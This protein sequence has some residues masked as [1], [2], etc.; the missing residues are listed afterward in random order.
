MGCGVLETSEKNVPGTALLTDDD[1][2]ASVRAY[3]E[4]IDVSNNAPGIVR[5][6]EA[7]SRI[8]IQHKAHETEI[9]Q[10][11]ECAHCVGATGRSRHY[12]KQRG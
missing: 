8:W 7:K 2:L 6:V 1:P 9:W 11:Q 5:F 4:D 12:L 10:R 3:G